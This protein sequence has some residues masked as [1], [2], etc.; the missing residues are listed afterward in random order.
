MLQKQLQ[1]F[2]KNR[3]LYRAAP[4]VVMDAFAEHPKLLLVKNALVPV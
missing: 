4:V 2:L 3:W 1:G